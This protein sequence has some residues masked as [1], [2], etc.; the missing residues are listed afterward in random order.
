MS[1]MTIENALDLYTSVRERSVALCKPL[2]A[3]DYVVQPVVEVS[4]PKW[5]LGHTTWFFET[6]FL[7]PY[8][9][10]Y[11]EFHPEYN[12]VFNS[13][14]ETVGA[15][16]LRT[17][18][19]NLSRP[20]VSDVYAYRAHVDEQMRAWICNGMESLD[21][22][23]MSELT[24]LLELGLNHEQQHQELLATDIKYIFGHNPLFPSYQTLIPALQGSTGSMGWIRVPENVYEIGYKGDGFCFDNEL[25][26][27]KVYIH[28][29]QIA[30]RL[31][32][33]AEYLEFMRSGGYKDFRHWL[34]EGWQWVNDNTVQAPMYWYEIDGQWMN[35]SPDGLKP[36]ALDE[37]VQH[38]SFYEADAYAA[39]IGARL[40]TE[41]EWEVASNQLQQEPQHKFQY[42]ELW[43][44]TNSAYLPYPGFTKAAGAIGEYN[45]KFMVNQMVLRGGSVATPAGHARRTYR[46]FFHPP[47]RWQF[48]GIRLV[49]R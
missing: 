33:N 49:K 9:T 44:W 39:W 7:K 2:Q 30:D 42:G 23:A 17:D 47:L 24:S 14:Y 18:R 1:F 46:N 19:G 36:I 22:N 40:A 41:F 43:E 6:F 4:P 31:V 10:G 13:Y 26:V 37:P 8:K 16:V 12:F 28:E 20:S 45:G 29:F 11:K 5:H 34:G 35:Y 21:N 32:T 27:H 38:V 48:M 25:G 15:R 3:E